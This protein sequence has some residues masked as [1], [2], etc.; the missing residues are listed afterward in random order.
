MSVG[1]VFKAVE[2]GDCGNC[3][4]E[5]E[6]GNNVRYWDEVLCHAK[7]VPEES[8]VGDQATVLVFRGQNQRPVAV[9]QDVASAAERPYRAYL[10]RQA[11]HNWETVAV[12]ENYPTWQAAR[13]DVKRYMAEAASLIAD[14]SRKELLE[15]SV[16]MLDALR[17]AVWDSAVNGNIAAVREAH[18]LVLSR[19][20]LLRLDQDIRDEE[21][22]LTGRTV[23]VGNDE[24]SYTAG[25]KAAAEIEGS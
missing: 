23:V 5:I 6:R 16:N 7:C 11:G 9:P 14:S 15:E 10:K 22:E 8:V 12:A 17:A 13:E 20:K 24:E 3:D 25:L 4:K 21:K 2:A 1:R 18:G 19:A